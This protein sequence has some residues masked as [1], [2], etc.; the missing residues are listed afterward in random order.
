MSKSKTHDKII[1]FTTPFVLV[2]F[3]NI[4]YYFQFEDIH[5]LAMMT[6]SY[7]FGGLYLS[8][9]LDIKSTPYLKWGYLRFLWIPYQKAIKHRS[10]LS[11]GILIGTTLRL[12]YLFFIVGIIIVSVKPITLVDYWE[13]V[14]QIILLDPIYFGFIFLSIELSALLHISADFLSTFL[15]KNKPS[16][17]IK[18]SLKARY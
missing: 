13:K 6:L 8:P 16:K 14:I 2:L 10:V 17:V 11:H 15:V 7:L 12:L 9:D 4:N 1:C 3:I 18:K 5:F